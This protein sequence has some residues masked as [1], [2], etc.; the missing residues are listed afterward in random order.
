MFLW[1]AIDNESILKDL[2]IKPNIDTTIY[3]P[4]AVLWSI[5][6]NDASRSGMAK[7]VG[8]KIYKQI[9]VRNVNTVRK[10]YN[11]ME[12]QKDTPN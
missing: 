1:E 11:L 5:D 6:K 10:I 7:I 2:T 4:G 3:I 9:T 12:N 8:S